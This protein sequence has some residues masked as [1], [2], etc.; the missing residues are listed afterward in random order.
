M[1]ILKCLITQDKSPNKCTYDKGNL[2]EKVRQPD[3]K[4]A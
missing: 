4:K 2:R 1:V 3:K